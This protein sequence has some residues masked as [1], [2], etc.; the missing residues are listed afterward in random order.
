MS[1]TLGA[2]VWLSA[3]LSLFEVLP[4]DNAMPECLA[5]LLWNTSTDRYLSA[6][7]S[8]Y[9]VPYGDNTVPR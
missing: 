6:K 3:M 5:T 8:L 9:E 1:R 7:R 4:G 2:N